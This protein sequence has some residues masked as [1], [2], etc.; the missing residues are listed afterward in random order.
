MGFKVI[1]RADPTS[2]GPKLADF[3]NGAF[4]LAPKDTMLFLQDTNIL[5]QR[6]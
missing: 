4:L 2:N 1:K 5:T 6:S 3:P